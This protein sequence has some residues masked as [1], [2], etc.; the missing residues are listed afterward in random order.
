MYISKEGLPEK[1]QFARD[2]LKGCKNIIAIQIF[3]C[4]VTKYDHLRDEQSA[5]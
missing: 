5:M 1:L 2:L 3:E 4:L